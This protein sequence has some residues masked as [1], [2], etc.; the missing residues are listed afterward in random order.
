M[1]GQC[2]A[3]YQ[4]IIQENLETKATTTKHLTILEFNWYTY[5]F[6]DKTIIN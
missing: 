1:E 5:C 2:A 6:D 4:W 3:S